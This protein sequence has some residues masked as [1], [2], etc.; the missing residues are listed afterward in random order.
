MLWIT[1][2]PPF[3]SVFPHYSLRLAGSVHGWYEG[4]RSNQGGRCNRDS[5]RDSDRDRDRDSDRDSDRDLTA[6][7][8]ES[9]L[10]EQLRELSRTL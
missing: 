6:V 4:R 9:I 3:S 1:G 7:R 10:A 5:D 2:G 8:F